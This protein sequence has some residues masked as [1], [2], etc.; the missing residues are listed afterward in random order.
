MTIHIPTMFLMIIAACGTLAFSVGFASRPKEEK[1]LLFWVV[2]MALQTLAFIL[3]LLRGQINDIL[4]IIVANIAISI[5]LSFFLAAIV[6]FLNC[7]ISKLIFI[8]PPLM[9]A[10]TFYFFLMNNMAARI[11]FSGIIFSA[12]SI[13]ALLIIMSRHRTIA[14]RGKYLLTGGYTLIIA[15]LSLRV[16]SVTFISD[17]I[18]AIFHQTSV[19]V[20]TFMATF[21]SLI[22]MSNG[23]VLMI[24]E[25]ADE[26]ILIMAMKD[27][28]TGVWN[29]IKL[30]STAQKEIAH[31]N[32]YGRSVSLIIIDIDHFKEINDKYGH[33]TGD[34]IL[35]EFCIVVQKCIRTTDILG[36]WGGE[37]FV[38]LLPN[39]GYLSAASLA[40]R[41][42]NSIERN[43]FSNGLHV[44]AS[45]GVAVCHT[46]DT[47]DSWLER[48]DMALYKAKL[49][50]RNRVE[51]ECLGFEKIEKNI[52]SKQDFIQ[53]IWRDDYNSGHALIDIEHRYL[54]EQ[55]NT[56]LRALLEKSSKTYIS[57]L[58]SAF[59]IEIET[60]FHHEEELLHRINYLDKKQHFKLHNDLLAHARTL[61]IDFEDSKAS[62]GELLHFIMYDMVSQHILNEDVKYFTSIKD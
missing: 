12:Q 60:H 27:R 61:L 21:I 32:R 28:L 51:K 38:I 16:Y 2:G 29:R 57:Q 58:I 43:V 7:N 62:N 48:A 40:E 3:F 36:R 45:L 49:A 59:I 53:L 24:K 10:V 17:E 30:E 37:E 35:K 15:V 11:I 4:T 41:V 26:R 22:L 1:E 13:F 8:T 9:L 18:V 33:R 52:S 23:F 19:Q 42:R 20:I 44:T 46:K 54:F 14:G 6:K 5:S 47:W 34:Q 56:L 55:A 31:F 39:S 50:G 25:R